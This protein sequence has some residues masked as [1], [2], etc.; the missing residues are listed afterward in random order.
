M[1]S[2]RCYFSQGLIYLNKKDPNLFH[3]DTFKYQ[4]AL[5]LGPYQPQVRDAGGSIVVK[6]LETAVKAIDVIVIQGEGSPG[7]YDDV[8][9]LEKVRYD[10]FLDLKQGDTTWEKLSCR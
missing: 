1:T 3:Q 7:P 9:K 5:G 2:S 4:F 8:D 6:D 10:I